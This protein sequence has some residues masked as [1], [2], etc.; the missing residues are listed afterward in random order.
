MNTAETIASETARLARLTARIEALT[1]GT[2][3]RARTLFALA[4]AKSYKLRKLARAEAA[5][6]A[7]EAA[8]KAA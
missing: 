2:P 1:P 8:K 6:A 3:H 7:E 5:K 4:R